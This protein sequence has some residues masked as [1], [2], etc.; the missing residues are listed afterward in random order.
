LSS[1][2]IAAM[3]TIMVMAD[4]MMMGIVIGGDNT[5]TADSSKSN[6]VIASRLDIE[7]SNRQG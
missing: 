3:A 1:F 5:S 4:V 2:A 6:K 7:C